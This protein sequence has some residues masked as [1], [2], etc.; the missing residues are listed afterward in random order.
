M[1]HLVN[2]GADIDW[3][4]HSGRTAFYYAC[5]HG[6]LETA[7]FLV[8]EGAD[9]NSEIRGEDKIY[10]GTTPIFVA[11]MFGHVD[12]AKW[13]VEEKHV[14]VNSGSSGDGRTPLYAAAGQGRLAVVRYLLEEG[15][16]DVNKPDNDGGEGGRGA[17]RRADNFSVRNEGLT[18][19]RSTSLIAETPLFRAC[20]E[21]HFQVVKC[22]LSKV[23]VDKAGFNGVTPLYISSGH[24]HLDIVKL[25][26]EE[27]NAD[28]DKG[29]TDGATPFFLACQQG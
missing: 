28:V 21:S 11:S 8:E 23:D 16:A 3:K 7:K 22:L 14:N 9:L 10:D 29:L 13:F 25:L 5:E 27:G 15:T 6:H 24:G 18:F 12:V 26:A 2:E 19:S 17:K 20:M 1:K 4:G